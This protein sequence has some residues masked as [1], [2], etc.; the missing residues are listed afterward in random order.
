MT[1]EDYAIIGDCHTACLVSKTGSIDWLCLPRFDSPA[2]FAALLG[3]A[4]NGHWRIA[5]RDDSGISISRRYRPDTLVLE[6]EFRT[7]NGTVRV[8]DF[9]LMGAAKPTIGRLVSGLAGSVPMRMKL[10]IRFDYGRLVPWVKRDM[11]DALTAVVGPHLLTLRTPAPH[12]G[13]DLSTVGEFTVS[14]GETVPFLLSY[15]ISYEAQP[16]PEDIFD[17]LRRTEAYWLNWTKQ[18]NYRGPWRDAVIRSLITLKALTYA[19]TGGMVAALTTSVPERLGGERNWDYRCC[20]L[21]DATFTLLSF[22]VAGYREEAEAWRRWLVRAIAGQTSQVQPLYTILGE[23]RLDEWEVPWLNGFAAS[24]PVRIGNAA[25]SQLQ[26]DV[27][28]EV[29]DALHH[30]RRCGLADEEET[31]RLEVAL[32]K[33]LVALHDEPDRGIW[34][35]R[36]DNRYFTHSKVMTWVAFDRAISGVEHFGLPGPVDDW[37]RLREALH[38]EICDKAFNS[39]LGSFVQAYGESELDASSLLIP[40]V[41]FLPPNDPRVIG[42]VEAIQRNL[43]SDGFVRRYD[44]AAVADGV[45]G[46]E[47]VFLICSFWLADNLVL[48]GR[49]DEG[50]RLFERLLELRND[51][52][53]LAE[54]YDRKAQIQLGNFPQALSHLSLVA[55]AYNLQERDGP[56]HERSKRMTNGLR[57]AAS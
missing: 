54:E 4:E 26:L 42:T 30:A 49:K 40:L 2:C 50:Q 1:I 52:G 7:R 21:R 56:A 22:L 31:W 35:M 15:G 3:E 44:T 23:N 46:S 38:Q 27:F 39:K 34:E 37:R 18:C 14:A 36:G 24:K 9:M 53:L 45:S 10:V 13:E 5:P 55:T 43:L 25:Y 19:P 47:G 28:G 17:G 51:V 12:H 48:Q 33:Q 11:E 41:G 8:T 16:E 57:G 32:L 6:T 20:W 29:L